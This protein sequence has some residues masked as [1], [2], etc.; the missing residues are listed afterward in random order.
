MYI[1][2][3]T[4]KDY[5]CSFNVGSNLLVCVVSRYNYSMVYYLPVF[6]HSFNSCNSCYLIYNK[7]TRQHC[8]SCIEAAHAITY[9]NELPMLA[10]TLWMSCLR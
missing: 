7:Y 9:M 5:P 8:L 1:F 10:Y 4:E 2:I 6:S 3:L